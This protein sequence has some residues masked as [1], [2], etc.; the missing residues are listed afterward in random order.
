MNAEVKK[1]CIMYI[2]VFK[3][4]SVAFSVQYVAE[5]SVELEGFSQHFVMW[6]IANVNSA[7]C[8]CQCYF[9][10]PVLSFQCFL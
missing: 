7:A 6:T 9:K 1:G 10:V 8:S 3:V 2:I 5:F 4:Y